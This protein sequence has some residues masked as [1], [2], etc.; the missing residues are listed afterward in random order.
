MPADTTERKS[1]GAKFDR[2]IAKFEKQESQKELLIFIINKLKTIDV[3]DVIGKLV[4]E[5]FDFKYSQHRTKP[6]IMR[7]LS[8]V[9]ARHL[10]IIGKCF[11]NINSE[12]LQKEW[13]K[14][15]LI[16]GA[17]KEYEWDKFLVMT[18]TRG[19]KQSAVKP[20]SFTLLVEEINRL[21]DDPRYSKMEECLSLESSVKA[22]VEKRKSEYPKTILD[23]GD[24][25]PDN[26]SKRLKPSPSLIFPKCPAGERAI[27]G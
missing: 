7:T 19:K 16:N 4:T 12:D 17:L 10:A 15:F 14:G 2:A 23:Y 9:C 20:L 27:K 22:T 21:S 8:I 13:Q 24:P 1:Q 11:L 26:V 25:N 3:S 5:L 6:D 18:A